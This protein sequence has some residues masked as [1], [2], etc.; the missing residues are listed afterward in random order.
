[1]ASSSRSIP[2]DRREAIA[3]R[4]IQKALRGLEYGTVTVIVQD[5]VVVQIDRTQRNRI[6]YSALDRVFGGEGI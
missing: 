4:E 2:P 1:M 3:L 5:G 6:D